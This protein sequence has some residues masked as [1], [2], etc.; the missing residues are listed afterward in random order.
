MLGE[1]R[2]RQFGH[3]GWLRLEV[4]RR[5]LEPARRRV[6]HGHGIFHRH[7]LPSRFLDVE[8]GPPE[9]RQ[10]EALLGDEQMRSVEFRRD[11]DGE[12]QLSHCRK[13]DV[14]IGHRHG[15]I[16]P[17]A[18]QGPRTAFADRFNGLDGVVTLLARRL[19][20]ECLLEIVEQLARGDFRDA[21]RAVALDVRVPTQRA[22]AGAFLADVA[23][24]QQQ[25]GDLVHVGRA[26]TVLGDAH[27]I[28]D[29]HALGLG[30]H[31]CCR[32]DFGTPQ[33][34]KSFDLRPV[35]RVDV[36]NERV[37][38]IRMSRR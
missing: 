17:E 25:V 7:A 11:M 8:F 16:A 21:D 32:L 34:S 22:D 30:V 23:A 24:H 13:R 37:E 38:A 33:P 35:G 19:D 36:G 2:Q 26:M 9:T 14:G 20:G 1:R 3:D 12:I 6:H 10:D 5:R 29:D 4:T 18:D 31:L 27:A 28:A 15:Q